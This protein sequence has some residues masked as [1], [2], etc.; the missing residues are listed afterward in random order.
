MAQDLRLRDR[1]RPDRH[2]HRLAGAERAA[3]AERTST[4][5]RRASCARCAA[6]YRR[7]LD[8]ALAHRALDARRRRLLLVLA[9]LGGARPRPR[10]PAQARGGQSVD[11]RHDAAV[12]LARGRQRLRQPDAPAHR[13]LSRG[14]RPSSRSTAGPTTA[15]M[16][17]GFFNAEFFVPLKPSDDLARA[18]STRTKL[19]DAADAAPWQRTFPG[20]EFNFS[21]Y[22]QDNVEEAA[23]G[24]K[25]ENSVKLFGNDLADAGEDR[26]A[27]QGGAG[28]ACPGITDLAVFNSLGQPTVRDRRR[29]RA[30]RALRPH[31]RRH[32]RDDPGR[33]RRPG[34][35]RPLRAGQRPP[36]PDRRA[37]RA[38]ST[39][40]ASTRSGSITIGAPNPGGNGIVQVPL[41]EVADGQAGVRRLVHLPRAAGALHSRSSSACAA[42]TSAARCSRRSSKVAQR[43]ADCRAATGSNG[44]ASSAICRRR[45]RGWRSWCR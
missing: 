41:S 33:D 13:E 14:A 35:R 20:V 34:R 17:T 44:S 37:A 6:R 12:D 22:I 3:A 39:A 43:G 11:P 28:D 38:A 10:V 40:A 36:L 19:T 16:P 15:P 23:S 1:R 2:L 21:Q 32:Q 5:P 9:S 24:V 8:F 26:R 7:L 27:D 29:P 31:A 42:A 4:R 30:R 25:G 45:W 18:A